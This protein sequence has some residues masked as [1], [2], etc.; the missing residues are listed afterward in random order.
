[1]RVVTECKRYHRYRGVRFMLDYHPTR[2]ELCQTDSPD[3]MS[4]PKVKRTITNSFSH[5]HTRVHAHPYSPTHTHVHIHLCT[6]THTHTPHQHP[7]QAYDPPVMTVLQRIHQHRLILSRSPHSKVI[8]SVQFLGSLHPPLSFD[9]Q[10]C[11]VHRL[12]FIQPTSSQLL[13]THV[14]TLAH[15]QTAHV[16]T[17]IYT[18]KC[19]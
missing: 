2:L 6:H 9:L 7:S 17:Q 11:Q 1:M 16:H 4:D 18:R 14:R 5:A 13:H 8:E 10:L 15:S 12:E 19:I 3:H